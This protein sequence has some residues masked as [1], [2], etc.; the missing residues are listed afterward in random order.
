MNSAAIPEVVFRSAAVLVLALGIG[1]VAVHTVL[2][3]GTGRQPGVASPKSWT[4]PAVVGTFLTFWFALAVAFGDPMNFPL[5]DE[6]L[7][8]GLSALL[9]LGPLAA[10]VV[11]IFAWGGMRRL[12]ARMPAHW[13]IRVQTYRVAGLIF[14]FPF[15]YYG[16]V[17]AAFAVPAGGGDFSTGALAPFVAWAVARRKPTA[18]RWA[19]AWNIFGLLDLVVA[20]AAAVLSGAAVLGLYPLSLVPLFIG[21]PL[22]ILTHVCS[23]WNL[24]ARA[25]SSVSAPASVAAPPSHRRALSGAI[26]TT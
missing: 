12:Y 18:V 15:L 19:V 10:A 22:G 13:L 9:A 23:L 7:R 21:P 14:L 11:A 5:E 3:A 17:P 20:P 25:S 24:S 26:R 2:V 16:M 1:M 4:L 6:A 8:P